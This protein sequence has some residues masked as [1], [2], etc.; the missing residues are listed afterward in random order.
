V[1]ADGDEASVQWTPAVRPY[2]V[3]VAAPAD[4]VH[5]HSLC[6]GRPTRTGSDVLDLRGA[7]PA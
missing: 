6:S 2:L 3:V 5:G 4:G 7:V 1:D